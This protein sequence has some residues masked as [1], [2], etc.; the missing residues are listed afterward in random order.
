MRQRLATPLFV[1]IIL[2]D[3][4]LVVELFKFHSQ[5]LQIAIVLALACAVTTLLWAE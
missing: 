1:L 2:L 5:R 4:L 3:A